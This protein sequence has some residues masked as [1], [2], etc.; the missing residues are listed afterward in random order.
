MAR[1]A[2]RARD[3]ERWGGEGRVEGLEAIDGHSI[4]GGGQLDGEVGW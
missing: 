3:L 4:S 2:T 1:A